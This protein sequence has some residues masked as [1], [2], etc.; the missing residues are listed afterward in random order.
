MTTTSTQLLKQSKNKRTLDVTQNEGIDT[1]E[2]VSHTLLKPEVT[3]AF[4]M[5]TWEPLHSVSGLRSALVKQ[6]DDVHNGSMERA[7]AMLLTQAHTLDALFNSLA[8]KAH[9]QAR[10]PHHESFLRLALKAQS[11]CRATLEALA[12][13]KNPPVIYAKQANISNG[14][15]QI[16]NMSATH[17]EK[18][19]ENQQNELLEQKHDERLDTRA[20]SKA[21]SAYSDL[22]ALE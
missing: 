17:S 19:Y 21:V 3:A 18:N 2:A 13:I 12:N 20:T 22:E 14:H 6:I 7:E 9:E 8:A 4:C 5:Q 15:Q 16:N 11:Q 10:L 1:N